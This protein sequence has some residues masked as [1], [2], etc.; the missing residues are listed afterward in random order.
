[1]LIRSLTALTLVG[2][3]S[4]LMVAEGTTASAV[5]KTSSL[6]DES[7]HMV[8]PSREPPA[9]VITFAAGS[10]RPDEEAG[11]A[12]M[13][14]A[15]EAPSI[16]YGTDEVII[17]GWSDKTF[18]PEH[19]TLTTAD[20]VLAEQRID[21]VARMVRQVFIGAKIRSYNFGASVPW[22]S[23][24]IQTDD[25]EV[26]EALALASRAASDRNRGGGSDAR[27]LLAEDRGNTVEIQQ[28]GAPEDID[29]AELSDPALRPDIFGRGDRGKRG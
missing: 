5:S 18:P 9:T 25:F 8:P 10:A 29:S 1:M 4:S 20:R 23:R 14:L 22:F 3:V 13:E 11:A 24:F 17:L 12:L 19:G 26:K 28:T 27:Q 15:E 2:V 6:T 16:G 21:R 7:G